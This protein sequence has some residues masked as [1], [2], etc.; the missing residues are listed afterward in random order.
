M[1]SDACASSLSGFLVYKEDRFGAAGNSVQTVLDA[2]TK[3]RRA[4]CLTGL[5]G[6]RSVPVSTSGLETILGLEHPAPQHRAGTARRR[7]S[8]SAECAAVT[9]DSLLSAAEATG[10]RRAHR[11]ASLGRSLHEGRA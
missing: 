2:V 4:Q 11:A 5:G 1:R 3:G 8:R 6:A 10:K 7:S 9:I